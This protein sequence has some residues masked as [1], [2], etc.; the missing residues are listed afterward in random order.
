MQIK[1]IAV[2]STKWERFIRR[3]GVSFLIEE[4]VLF[5]T[6]GNLGVFLNNM[7]KFNI[8]ASKIKHIVLS[9]DD[10][11]HISGL[12]YLLNNWKDITV[13]ICPSF[14]AEIKERIRSFGVKVIEA[15]SVILIKDSVYSTGELHGKS[16]GHQ[17]YEH[18]L[19]IDTALGLSVICGCVHPGIEKIIDRATKQFNKNIFMIVGGLHLKN[20]SEEEIVKVIEFL[21]RHGV[22]KVAPMHC[23]G[24][25]ATN[26]IKRAYG[27]YCIQIKRGSVLEV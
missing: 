15:S 14:K 23:T 10:W 26:L 13:Y 4:D 11:D 17:I 9:H 3:W 21:R 6:F 18:S 20:N 7:Q 24:K 27:D 5:D 22:Q 16:G 2:G 12:W 1:V 25:L 8:D 19:V